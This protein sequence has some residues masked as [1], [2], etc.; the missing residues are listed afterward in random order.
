MED[1]SKSKIFFFCCLVFISGIALASFFP[2]LIDS[3]FF[4]FG[5]FA[6]VILSIIIWE[7]KKIRLVFLVGSFLFLAFWRFGVSLEDY[8]LNKIRN[9]NGGKA[10]FIGVITKE[11][12]IREDKIKYEIEVESLGGKRV[13]GKVLANA[14]LYPQFK[15]GDKVHVSCRLEAPEKIEDF[16]YDR[17]LA[18][19][20]I[21]SLCYFPKMQLL[22]SGEGNLF[23]AKIFAL[24]DSVREKIDRCLSEPE[25]G[26]AKG[27]ILGDK[28]AID[29]GL[30]DKFAQIGISH[31]VAISGAN[32]SILI[33]LIMVFAV[34]I[35]L[36]RR[37]S[38]YFSSSLLL[39]YI[40]L[41]GF[42]AS[43]MR[44]GLMGFLVLWGIYL[45]RLSKSVN[46][47]VLAA[48]VML[49]INPK[50]LRDDIG[51]QLSFLAMLSIIVL[52][53]ILDELLQRI[54]IPNKFNL[55]EIVAMT[56]TAQIFTL[57]ILVNNFQQ[58]SL[59]FL[60]SNFFVLWTLPILMVVLPISIIIGFFLE[61][62][63][64]FLVSQAIL[65]FIVFVAESLSRFPHASIPVQKISWLVWIFY[66]SV[67]AYFILRYKKRRPLN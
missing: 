16:A 34:G 67:L 66:Y 17:Y 23:F 58:L 39:L 27:F 36:S 56:L 64:V 47:L 57:P 61:S 37:K 31:I 22:S 25:S 46:A 60:L 21:Y 45:G 11:P 4:F 44:A 53:P 62:P 1:F 49:F 8:E 12:D 65:K 40:I 43:A 18:R 54:K 41:V 48:S 63:V 38:F 6:S 10:D 15:Y 28:K 9:H 50:I 42:P 20:D 51:F 5:F 52:Y 24:K 55:R 14:G 26:L 35:G 30:N 59:V 32:V 3:Y 2:K 7:Y 13:I 29:D 19:Y 33:N